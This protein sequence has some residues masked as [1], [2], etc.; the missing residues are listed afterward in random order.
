MLLDI[1]IAPGC[2]K[3][4]QIRSSTVTRKDILKIHQSAAYGAWNNLGAQHMFPVSEIQQRPT[5]YKF[6]TSWVLWGSCWTCG[7]WV[8]RLILTSTHSLHLCRG[9]KA[10]VQKEPVSPSALRQHG[11]LPPFD[12]TCLPGNRNEGSVDSEAV[13]P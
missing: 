3:F 6:D 9:R 5:S 7:E 2:Q 10:K 8:V 13:F 4:P 11:H 1:A 12:S